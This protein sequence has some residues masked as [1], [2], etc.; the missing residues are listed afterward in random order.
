MYS[1]IQFNRFIQSFT[2]IKQTRVLGE[3]KK[4]HKCFMLWITINSLVT[5]LLLFS[6]PFTFSNLG[7]DSTTLKYASLV[8]L[9]FTSTQITFLKP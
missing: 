6:Q 9:A 3:S 2:A 7:R 8:N 5:I 4:H 1:H